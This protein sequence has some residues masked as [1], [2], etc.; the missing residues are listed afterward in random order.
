MPLSAEQ[1]KYINENSKWK[2]PKEIKDMV[3]DF[4]KTNV[5]KF[6][7]DKKRPK[8]IKEVL[9]VLQKNKT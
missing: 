1:I 6:I 3:G 5:R 2:T 9:N 4:Y 8:S 7:Q